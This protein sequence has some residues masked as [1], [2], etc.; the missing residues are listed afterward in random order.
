MSQVMKQ[1]QI[2]V[3]KKK[4]NGWDGFWFVHGIVAVAVCLVGL[5]LSNF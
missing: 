2:H 4:H 3:K 5:I 1:I